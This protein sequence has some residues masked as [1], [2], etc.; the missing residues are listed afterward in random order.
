MLSEAPTRPRAGLVPQSQRGNK[1]TTTLPVGVMGD[2]PTLPNRTT[3]TTR[4]RGLSS[5]ASI[6][7]PHQ[8]TS[9]G[10]LSGLLWVALLAW[11]ITL[12]ALPIFTYPLT[13]DQSIF[14]IIG[15]RIAEGGLPYIDAWDVKPP[16]IYYTYALFVGL[17]GATSTALRMMD[18]TLV[19]LMSASLAYLALRL[20]GRRAAMWAAL[21][22][23]I[24]YFR[25]IFWTMAQN[26][27]VQ[28]LPMTLAMIA[29]YKAG[30]HPS[31]SRRAMLWTVLCGVCCGIVFWFKYPFA[32]FGVALALAHILRR[33]ATPWR[34]MLREALA[35][36]LGVALTIFGVIA[37]MVVM[38]WFDEWMLHLQ[39]VL[40]LPKGGEFLP[41]LE[42][43]VYRL[44]RQFKSWWWIVP[45][46]AVWGL[47][48]IYTLVNFLRERRFGTRTLAIRPPIE[49]MTQP[50]RWREWGLVVIPMFGA[51]AAIFSQGK[52]YE[53]H[54]LPM[55]PAFILMAADGLER[56][57]TWGTNRLK[58]RG[59]P[60]GYNALATVT[61]ASL[62]IL[63]GIGTWLP[64]WRYMTG[65]ESQMAYYA[66]FDY[67]GERYSA[68]ESLQVADYL[69]EHT[70]RDDTL[71]IWGMRPEVYLYSK[72]RPASRFIMHYPVASTWALPEWQTEAL[73]VLRADPPAYMLVLTND[74]I[75]FVTGYEGD[76]LTLLQQSNPLT[77]W[78]RSAYKPEAEI[79]N[80]RVWAYQGDS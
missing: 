64:S 15:S 2:S 31:G 59:Q 55:L 13:T 51:L 53:Y 70:N 1:T 9:T 33:G 29:A 30:D 67:S 18:I 80:F 38:G 28:M 76:S 21:L 11:V 19:I 35:Y 7:V 47:Y 10:I 24:L 52:G 6:A 16:A 23:S 27:G 36:A 61:A 77:D 42:T 63:L 60:V 56:L 49:N 22:F 73:E 57:L 17:F 48:S 43:V 40:E 3:Y 14:T 74:S 20:S 71:F 68:Q 25:E 46:L 12:L 5:S 50:L 66:A 32:L 78:L 75:S 34:V 8:Q 45:F 58:L 62:L 41:T 72:L 39:T 69:A 26:D 4:P 79:G 54:W 44:A 65:Q 37:I